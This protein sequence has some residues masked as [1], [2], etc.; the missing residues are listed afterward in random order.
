MYFE[1]FRTMSNI[2]FSNLK[3]LLAEDDELSRQIVATM[4]ED[5]GIKIDIAQNGQEALTKSGVT[6][7]D[8]ILMDMEMPEMDGLRATLRYS[9]AGKK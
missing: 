6:D 5:K 9:A 2:D 1:S 3:I 4:L 7:Y 8:I